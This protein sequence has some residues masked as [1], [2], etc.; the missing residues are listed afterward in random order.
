MEHKEK[1]LL[2]EEQETLLI[3]L[4]SKAQDN[5]VLR[6]EKARQILEQVDY[7]F[8]QLKVPYKTVVTVNIR[9]RQLDRYTSEFIDQ[10]PG[11]VILH[12]GCGLDSR[13]QRVER[14]ESRW[15]DLDLPKV[16][17]LRRKFYPETETYHMIGSSVTEAAWMEQVQAPGR[18]VL[19]VAEGLLMYLQEDEVRDL[20][21]GLHQRYPGCHLVFDAFS[22]LTASRVEAHPSLQKTG[23]RV[24]WGIDDPHE[25]ESWASDQGIRLREEW[26]FSQAPEI[27]RLS[28]FYRFMFRFTA[29][30]PVVQRAQRLLYYIL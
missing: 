16:I 28:G 2:D 17:A 22:K 24:H 20:I 4:Y 8:G 5:P 18:P 13:C 30:F 9:A 15:F 11:A 12:L 23:A 7:D 25:I 10:N 6:D 19:V 21:L 26:F 14:R 3:P 1:I 27:E 29:V